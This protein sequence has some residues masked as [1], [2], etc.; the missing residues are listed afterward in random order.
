MFACDPDGSAVWRA[1]KPPERAAGVRL[2]AEAEQVAE[3]AQLKRGGLQRERDLG[4]RLDAVVRQQL[5]Q[6][7]RRRAVAT[8]SSSAELKRLLAQLFLVPVPAPKRL[9]ALLEPAS[10]AKER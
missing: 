10:L 4:D 7:D 2:I 3:P 1:P 9:R 8:G 6:P 5:E